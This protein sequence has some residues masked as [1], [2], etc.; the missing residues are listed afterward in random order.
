MILKLHVNDELDE[1]HAPRKGRFP[2]EFN[3]SLISLIGEIALMNGKKKISEYLNASLAL[4]LKDL[5]A[6]MDR[7][8][9]FDLVIAF[10]NSFFHFPY[11]L[12]PFFRFMHI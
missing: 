9:V 3:N 5:F 8:V 11:L 4:F 2:S 10:F 1:N 6:F 12:Q 7:G